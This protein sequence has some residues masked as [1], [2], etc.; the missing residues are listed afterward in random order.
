MRARLEQLVG[1]SS[2]ARRALPIKRIADDFDSLLKIEERCELSAHGSQAFAPPEL[3]DAWMSARVS[4]AATG[5]Q[6]GDETRCFG[7]LSGLTPRGAW[8]LDVYALGQM[9]RYMLTGEEPLADGSYAG[10]AKQKHQGVEAVAGGGDDCFGCCMPAPT[11]LAA[12][13]LSELD[14]QVAA[15]LARMMASDASERIDVQQAIDHPWVRAY[16]EADAEVCLA[17]VRSPTGAED[18]S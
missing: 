18:E 1:Y 10:A 8:A 9:L 6:H 5:G 16:A 7:T 3:I 4:Q 14:E 15:L 17:V 12:R 2:P 13:Q 11:P